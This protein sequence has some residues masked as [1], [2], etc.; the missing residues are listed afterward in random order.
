MMEEIVKQLMSLVTKQT[1]KIKELKRELKESSQTVLLSD[2]VYYD[3][4]TRVQAENLKLQNKVAELEM[5]LS[6]ANFELEKRNK[7]LLNAGIG[8]K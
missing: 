8:R 1:R 4:Y 7:A 2:N 5:K 6:T 3:K